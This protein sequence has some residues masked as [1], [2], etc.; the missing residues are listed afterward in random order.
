MTVLRNGENIGMADLAGTSDSDIFRMMVGVAP[1]QRTP[2]GVRT[3]DASYKPAINVRNLSGTAISEVSFEVLKGEIVGVAALAGQGQRE[4]FRMLAGAARIARGTVEIA[5]RPVRLAS[6]AQA[7]RAGIGFL[8]EDRKSE[9][10]FLGL[11]TATNISLPIVGQLLR[12]GLIE[13]RRERRRVAE[14]AR[15]V[16]L[17]ERSL[18]MNI[19]TLSGGNQQKALLARVLISGAQNLVLFDPTRGVD[20]GTK[21]VI[22][23]VIR[24]FVQAGGSVLIYS[25]ELAELVQLVHRCLVMYRGRIIGEVAGNALSEARLVSLATGHVEA[26]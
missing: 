10:I 3:P 13:S 6:P 19:A 4:L 24:R 22:Y 25:T 18:H 16:D 12:F 21:Q 26:T 15:R 7:L 20:V 23:G 5:G 1:E 9:G 11:A 2:A 17:A 14:Q 8:P